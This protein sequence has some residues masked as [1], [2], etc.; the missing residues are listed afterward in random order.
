MFDIIIITVTTLHALLALRRLTRVP[1]YTR[2]VH[3][4]W[5]QCKI[6]RRRHPSEHTLYFGII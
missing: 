5:K 3:R 6:M 2:G 4:N 1:A